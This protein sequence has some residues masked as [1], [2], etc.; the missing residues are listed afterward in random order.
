MRY[1]YRFIAAIS[2]DVSWN[3]M[4][5]TSIKEEMRIAG[6]GK[7]WWKPYKKLVFRHLAFRRVRKIAKSDY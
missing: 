4:F 6:R 2:H 7:F 3:S 1:T 5:M